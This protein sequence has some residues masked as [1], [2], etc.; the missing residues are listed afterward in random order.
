M[1]IKA[2]TKF[3]VKEY[4]TPVF[5]LKRSVPFAV[6]GRINEELERLEKLGVISKVDYSEW[7]SLTV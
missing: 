6:L 2:K 1:G 4:A 5:R 3:E 7:T